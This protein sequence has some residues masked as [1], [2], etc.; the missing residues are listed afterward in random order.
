MKAAPPGGAAFET[1]YFNAKAEGT[2]TLHLI[3]H[4]AWLLAVPLKDTGD[5]LVHVG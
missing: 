3:H 5:F 4:Q 1:F 2:C